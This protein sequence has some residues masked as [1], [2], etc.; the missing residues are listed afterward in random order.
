MRQYFSQRTGKNSGAARLSLPDVK[1][2]FKSQYDQ[3][4]DQG[5]F[6]EDLGFYC[7]DADFIPGKLGTDLPAELLLALRK[8][9]LWPFH[10]TIDNWSED[11]L[12]DVVEFLY[13]HVSQ[14]TE[15]SYHSYGGCGW[16]CSKFDRQ[17]GQAEYR[18]KIDRLLN[19]YSEGFELTDSGQVLALPDSGLAPLMEA[20]LPAAADPDNITARVDAAVEKFRRHRSSLNDR[21]DAIR[22]LADVLEYLRPT[23]KTVLASKDEADLFNIANNFG[24]RHHNAAQKVSYD[25]AIWYSWLFYYYLATIHAALRLIERGPA[26]PGAA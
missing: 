19:S 4:A 15:K 24:I 22:D 20:P 2:L 11:D 16:H 1:R 18:A 6:Q 12:F 3:L 25:R 8:D 7:V 9:N 17:A 10:E 21:R 23:I 13:D 26:S 5:Y 14:P